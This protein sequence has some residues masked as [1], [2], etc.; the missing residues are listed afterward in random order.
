MGYSMRLELSR[1]CDL[2][3]FLFVMGFYKGHTHFFLESVHLSL[4]YPSWIFDMFLSFCVCVYV[5]VRVLELFWILLT[6]IFHLC[7]CVCVLAIF[8]VYM[9]GSVV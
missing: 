5:C 9:C 8:C 1:V 2:N 3:D 4:L 6:V 7:I